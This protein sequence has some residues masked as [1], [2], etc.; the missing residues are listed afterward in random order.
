MLATAISGALGAGG[1]GNIQTDE[2]G[3]KMNLVIN[4]RGS[5][6]RYTVTGVTEGACTVDVIYDGRGIGLTFNQWGINNGE[7][8]I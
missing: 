5:S 7:E 3:G 2:R 1:G 6:K 8:D 4:R